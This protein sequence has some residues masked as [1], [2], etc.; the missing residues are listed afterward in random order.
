[1]KILKIQAEEWN[2][3]ARE[4]RKSALKIENRIKN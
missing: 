3:N 1:M 4:E 2:L